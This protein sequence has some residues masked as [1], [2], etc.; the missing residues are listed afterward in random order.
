M[1]KPRY[2]VA[3]LLFLFSTTMFV[4]TG[5][6]GEYSHYKQHKKSKDRGHMVIANRASGSISVIDV[7]TDKVRSTI[8]LPVS[9][10]PPEPMYVVHSPRADRVFV[11]D[12]ANNRIVV[13]DD[14]NFEYE[15][16]VPAGNGV[17][18]M[19]ADQND[20]QLWVN[21]DIDKTITVI[22]PLTLDVLAT[23][24]MPEDLVA[25]G[26]KPHD[27]ILEP[28]GHSAFVTIVGISGE[29]D[30]VVKFNTRTFSETAR[31]AVGKDPHVSLTRHNKFLYV[32]T[33]NNNAMHILKRRNLKQV[34][35]LEIPGAHG[36]GM[37]RKGR[38]LYTTNISGGGSEG[39][40]TIDT[41]K[42]K[43]IGQAIDTPFPTPHNIALTPRGSK[44]YITHSG[45]GANQVSVYRINK[46]SRLPELE[47]TITVE[48]NPFG[49]AFVR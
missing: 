36:L 16:S 27:V 10:N 9:D 3:S 7:R 12:R 47:T 23:V 35:I 11:G 26:G 30:F 6:A 24:P 37:A 41:R 45:A 25:L 33:Q 48:F 14:N 34:K 28:S 13:F 31:A 1:K 38:T 44:L 42:N 21:N 22:D 32:A 39:L 46:R 18:H 49:L 17:F 2:I 5:I 43:I 40:F 29:N 8:T 19:W 15:T 20:E 4:S